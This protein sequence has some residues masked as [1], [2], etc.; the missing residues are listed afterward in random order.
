MGGIIAIGLILICAAIGLALF[1]FWI[2]M[3]VHALT[4]NGL[5]GTEKVAW[6]LV[7]VFVQLLGA[8]IYFFVG[9][10]KAASPL[11]IPP[12]AV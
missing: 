2:W 12:N 11:P 5:T 1:A 4:N 9:K 8:I 10:P 7:I 3:L 6:V